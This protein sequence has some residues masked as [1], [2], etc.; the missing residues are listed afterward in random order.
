MRNLSREVGHGSVTIN[1]LSL[2]AMDN[3]DDFT[4]IATIATAVDRAGTAVDVAAASLYL[5]SDEASWMMT[6]QTSV[7]NGGSST[8]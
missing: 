2:G 3:F 1:A 4:N 6:G 7:L 5:I 8:A